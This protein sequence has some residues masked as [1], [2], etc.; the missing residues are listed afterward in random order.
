MVHTNLAENLTTN[1]YTWIPLPTIPQ[2]IKQ[3]PISTAKWLSK[4]WSTIEIFNSAKVEYENALENSGYHHSVK[5]SYIQTREKN[6]NIIEVE[7]SSGL[8][9]QIPKTSL[10]TLQN[11]SWTYWTITSQNRIN[12]TRYSTEIQWKLATHAQTISAVLSVHTT[13]N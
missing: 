10:P 1:Y 8:N 5:L 7:T 3:I 12:C 6:R 2:I 4:K 11:V 9:D 13:R